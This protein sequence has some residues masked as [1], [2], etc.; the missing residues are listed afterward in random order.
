MSRSWS[1]WHLHSQSKEDGPHGSCLVSNIFHTCNRTIN[2]NSFNLSFVLLQRISSTFV[3]LHMVFFGLPLLTP[4][5]WRH[6]VSCGLKQVGNLIVAVSG[7]DKKLSR[8][9]SDRGSSLWGS[10]GNQG[11]WPA[12][13][14]PA[15]PTSC[16]CRLTESPESSP[17]WLAMVIWRTKARKVTTHKIEAAFPSQP[18]RLVL[19]Q[20]FLFHSHLL[21]CW[22]HL[23]NS[24]A[25]EAR[26][27][28]THS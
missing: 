13:P 26:N 22:R 18:S 2:L 17:G 24:G 16:Y 9:H 11:L 28:G 20:L 3:L 4:V 21:G 27:W 14:L 8:A 6:Y 5:P 25:T 7:S 23:G 19:L 15:F 12:F 1:I 10:L